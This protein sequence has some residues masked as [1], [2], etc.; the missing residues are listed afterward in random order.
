M[1]QRSGR[2]LSRRQFVKAAGTALAAGALPGLA[3]KPG[4]SGPAPAKAKAKTLRILQWSHFVPGY[5]R[6][7]DDVYTKEWGAKNGLDVIVDHMAA[8]EV[9]ARGASEA[10]AKKGHDLFLFI[11]PPARY[12]NQVIDHR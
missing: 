3:C 8:T 7:F 12:E 2:R 6:W 11:S 9:S 4:A 5:G 10:A 1:K